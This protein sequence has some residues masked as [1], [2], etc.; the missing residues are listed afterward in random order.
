MCLKLLHDFYLGTIIVVT[1]NSRCVET[2]QNR[3]NF[4][5]DV[6]K[7]Y[8]QDQYKTTSPCIYSRKINQDVY[9]IDNRLS[10]TL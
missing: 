7:Q 8:S 1:S 9:N 4:T 2:R 3:N 6:S 10:I 5:V